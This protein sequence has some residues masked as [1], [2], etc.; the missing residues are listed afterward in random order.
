MVRTI[1][2]RIFRCICSRISAKKNCSSWARRR[3]RS[4]A[5]VSRISMNTG[6]ARNS[7]N[8]RNW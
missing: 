7:T 8:S 3:R 6:R 4:G 5:R 2:N 1:T